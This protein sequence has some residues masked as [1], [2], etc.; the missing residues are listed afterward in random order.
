VWINDNPEGSPRVLSG[1][2]HGLAKDCKTIFVLDADPLTG[3][4]GFAGAI[5]MI[6][7]GTGH[8]TVKG[9]VVNV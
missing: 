2:G 3:A 6:G 7:L 1:Y 8:C 5:A 4:L 9:W